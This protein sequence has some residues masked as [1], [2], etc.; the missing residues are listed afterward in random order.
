MAVAWVAVFCGCA[1]ASSHAENGPVTA[2]PE[3]PLLQPSPIVSRNREASATIV[4]YNNVSP[5]SVELAQYYAGKRGI[6]PAQVVGL[7]CS[8]AEE[9]SREEY[10][11]TIADPLRAIFTERDWWSVSDGISTSV[12][13]RRNKIRFVVLMHGMP[14]KIAPAPGYSGDSQQGQPELTS[15]SEAAVD[16]ELATLGYFSRKISGVL[17][18]PFFRSYTRFL[19][20]ELAPLMIVCRLDGPSPAVVRR[21]INDSLAAERNGLWGFAY[22]DARGLPGG[23]LIEGDQWMM[24]ASDRLRRAGI[25][26]ILDQHEPMYP[27]DYPMR[28]V[29]LYFGWYSDQI[30]GPLARPD[31]EFEPGAIAYHIHSF[32]AAT[33]RN[34][35]AQWAGPLLAHGA[36]ATMGNVYEPYLS[37]TPNV[38][39]FV[40]RLLNGF[41]FGEAAYMCSR[42]LSWM[43]TFVGD[44]L[45]RPFPALERT[46]REVPAATEWIAYRDGAKTWYRESAAAGAQRL[47]QSGRRL[48]SGVIFEGLGLL[49]VAQPDLPGALQSFQQA[50]QLYTNGEDVLRVS[51]HETAALLTLQKKN[52]ALAFVRSQLRA[53]PAA[54]GVE[55]LKSIE[56]QLAPPSPAPQPSR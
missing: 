40:D 32:S 5:A 56:L 11:R 19:D 2:L 7:N 36:A 39:I 21:M 51:I 55:I 6:P 47:R 50:R 14:L 54:H 34:P 44:P 17:P 31:F 23:P 4:V 48:R 38:E 37:L 13:V 45:Y 18:N 41:T 9:I 42:A 52:E 8:V 15:K 49:Q 16:S 12:Y 33:V 20:T 3:V 29:A 43:T 35:S 46:A 25:P 26:L 22:I 30:S 53:Y 1:W 28:N 27:P 24:K 10:D